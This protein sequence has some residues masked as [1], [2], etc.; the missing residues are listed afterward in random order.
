MTSRSAAVQRTLLLRSGLAMLGLALAVGA[1]SYG[2]ARRD[3]DQAALERARLGVELLRQGV[4]RRLA[5]GEG[6]LARALENELEQPAAILPRATAGRFVALVLVGA[7]GG[8]SL[9]RTS[10]G[11]DGLPWE[12]LLG[13]RREDGPVVLG[14]LRAA[15]RSLVAVAAPFAARGGESGAELRGWFELSG[16]ALAE[17]DRR[18]R[19]SALLA[20][21]VVLLTVVVLYP[22]VRALLERQAQ[23]ALSLLDANLESLAMLGSA[24]AKRDADTD[25]HNFRV[26]VYAVR[27]AEELA[28]P[29]DAIRELIQGAFVHDVGKIGVRDAV[30]LKPGRLDEGELVEMRRHVEHGLAI[31]SRSTWLAGAA[32]IVGGHHEKFDGSGYPRGLVGAAIPLAARIFALADVFDAVTSE[33]PYHRPRTLEEAL[34]LLERGRGSHFDPALLDRFLALAPELHRLY[35]DRDEAPRRATR[36]LVERYFREAAGAAYPREPRIPPPDPR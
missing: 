12:P 27:L 5:A 20:A 2:L 10:P 30:L 26:V 4:E 35:A 33:R 29:A 21:A 17:L 8:E 19:R 11:G 9:R 36:A 31:V 6:P 13:A 15:G 28:Q 32:T 22:I 3:L 16:P 24:I 34:E 25:A 14:R 1:G 18:A 23:A 7:D